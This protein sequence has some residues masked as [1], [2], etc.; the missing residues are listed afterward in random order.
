[1]QSI[2]EVPLLLFRD[3]DT[4]PV[5]LE[6]LYNLHGGGRGYSCKFFGLMAVEKKYSTSNGTARLDHAV[7]L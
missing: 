7:T 4:F 6:G 2:I 3:I 1:M 5:Q